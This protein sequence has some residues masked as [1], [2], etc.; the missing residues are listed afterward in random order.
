MMKCRKQQ[1][2]DPCGSSRQSYEFCSEWRYWEEMSATEIACFL[3]QDQ[4]VMTQGSSL[5]LPFSQHT[6]RTRRQPR[7]QARNSPEWLLPTVHWNSRVGKN[8]CS[9][10]RST[11]VEPREEK[12]THTRQIKIKIGYKPPRSACMTGGIS[13]LCHLTS[14]LSREQSLVS[15]C[16]S[17]AQDWWFVESHSWLRS[18]SM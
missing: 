3:L 12:G 13:T 5:V 4:V 11:A 7:L 2:W 8:R 16:C 15:K 17:R 9:I 18:P 10:S 6:D 1:A 14:E